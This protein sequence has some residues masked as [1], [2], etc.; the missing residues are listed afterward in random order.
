MAK[1]VLVTE[2]IHPAG[3]EML[4]KE[5]EVV[6]CADITETTLKAA[7]ADVDGILVRVAPMSRAVLGAAKK[8]KVIGKHGVGIDNIDVPAATELGIAVCN[9]PQANSEGVA[10]LAITLLL[11]V[12][13]RLLENDRFVRAGR[14]AG[15]DEYMGYEPN[16]KTLSIVGTGRIG[17]RLAQIC[18]SAFGMKV[19]AY[20]PYVSA[21]AMAAQGITKVETV[22]ELMPVADYVSIH[23]PL[24]PSTKG[25]VGA[26]QFDLMKKTAILINTSRGPVVDEVALVEA[27]RAGKIAAA[28]LDVFD[29]EPPA[30]DNPLLGLDNVILLP[31]MGGATYESM[32]RMATHAAA[33]ILAILG[34]QK[35]RYLRNPEVL[36]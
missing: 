23:T 25:I 30:K 3:I 21:E 29:Q 14:W 12:S 4:E 10:S 7:I 26:K 32:E 8:L 19:Y 27:L 16:G 24:T 6:R 33:E 34:G 15:K 18:Q 36:K 1:K 5:C 13:R 20:D 31:H 17:G 28:G 9:T 2:F 22:D 11:S 35:P